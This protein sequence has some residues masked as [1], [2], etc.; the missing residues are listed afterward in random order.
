[1]FQLQATRKGK[2]YPAIRFMFYSK[3]EAMRRYRAAYGLK[4]KQVQWI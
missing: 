1:M 3:V 4:G 2:H